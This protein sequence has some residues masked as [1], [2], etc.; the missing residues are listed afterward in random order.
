LFLVFLLVTFPHEMVLRRLVN[1][2]NR[3]PLGLSFGTA[4]IAPLKGYELGGFRIGG[5]EEGQTPVLETSKVWIRPQFG[6]LLRG[7]PYAMS[8][9]SEL[10]GG[11]LEG[12]V[13]Y[14]DGGIAGTLEWKDLNIGRYRALTSQLEEGEIAGR[15][16]GNVTFDARGQNFQQ[17][18]AN[19]DIELNGAAL[20]KAKINGWPIPDLQLKQT[21][22][23]FK[24]SGGR[25]DLTDLTSSGD[26][27]LQGSG[28]ILLKEPVGESSLNLRAT[29]TAT[30]Q[31]PDVL[32]AAI[33][34]IPR[35]QG[36][37]PDAPVTITGTLSRPRLR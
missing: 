8:I 17:G 29:I 33:A 14:K 30:P 6:E 11:T 18:Q 31:T 23:K 4:G 24:V 9:T 22:A 21:R 3:G 1:H 19:G 12:S 32:K 15:L 26:V 37:K 27:S 36:S 20:T 10:Y 34:L 35:P 25:L 16:S 13:A 2:L 28:Q 5:D 7:N